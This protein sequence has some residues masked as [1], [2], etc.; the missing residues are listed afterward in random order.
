MRTGKFITAAAAV[1]CVVALTGC[2]KLKSR[3]QLNQGVVAFR[4]AKYAES[5]DHF[6]Q[7]IALDDSNP[8]ARLYLATAY[9]S[10]WI[11]GAESPENTDMANKARD[12]FMKVLDKNPNEPTAIASLA[13]ISYN[14]ASSLP[15]DQKVAKLDEAAK[16]YKRLIEV[17][18]KNKEA[19]YSLG[20]IDWAKWYPNE[21]IAKAN[22]H[23]KPEDPGPIKDKKVKEDLKTQYGAIIDDGIANLNKALEI[24]PQ[25]EDA[26]SYLNLLIREKADLLDSSDEYKQ[27]VQIAD[28]WIQKALDTKKAKAAAAAAHSN[29]G[30]TEEPAK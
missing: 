23:M 27:Q 9:M 5:V 13:S 15:P 11:P 24:D 2:D 12:E 29:S 19:Y 22:L 16:W 4:N 18:P 26:M 10:Q 14:E 25:Y 17:D 8:Y 21:Q 20:V 28:G 6:K 30:I 7:A 1:A 3:D